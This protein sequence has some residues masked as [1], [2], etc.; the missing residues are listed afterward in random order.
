M[1]KLKVNEIFTSFDGEVNLFG[2]MITTFVRF[3]GCNLACKY[4]DTKH[5]TYIEMTPEEIVS[6]IK[7]DKVTFTGGEPFVQ[8][9]DALKELFA[10]LDRKDKYFTLET[11][12]TIFPGSDFPYLSTLNI[13][14]DYKLPGS[15]Y[16]VPNFDE[17]WKDYMGFSFVKFVISTR[18]DY[19][20]AKE[21]AEEWTSD[22]YLFLPSWRIA[23][24]PTN[25]PHSEVTPL[26]LLDWMI[27]DNL[28]YL[29]NLQQH[30]LI[31]AK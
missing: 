30:K 25:S 21:V 10:L 6:K 23:F 5:D 17:A 27:Q 29:L 12:G 4:C 14:L 22:T 24:S 11:N 20:I 16:I 31:G 15:G 28:P 8:D 13:V 2:P 9:L 7:T 19:R 3:S 26:M 1:K 18:K